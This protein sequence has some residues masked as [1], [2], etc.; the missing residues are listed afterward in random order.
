MIS[1]LQ[2]LLLTALAA[3]S[4]PTILH[5]MGRRLPPTVVFPALRYLTATERE[6][7]RRLKL[8]NLLLL[9]LR[10]L[11][12]VLVVA[13]AARPVAR[14]PGGSSHPPTAVALVVDNSLS[15][16]TVIEGRRV[17]DLLVERAREVV[18]RT[19]LE[20]R[21]WLVLADGI[22]RRQGRAEAVAV[23]DSLAPWA[24]RL[25]LG[26]AVRAAARAVA[27]EPL[28]GHEVVVLSDLQASAL[29]SGEPTPVRVLFADPPPTPANRGIDT[30][31][32]EPPVWTPTGSVIASVGGTADAPV[33]VSLTVNERDVAR[34]V[35]VPGDRVVLAG[36]S[37]RFG[38]Q[39][40][41]VVLDP[42]ELRLDDRW[43]IALRVIPPVAASAAPG[44]GPFVGEALDV[45]QS[46]GRAGRGT[47]V[48]LD[49][50]VG[51]GTTVLFPPADPSLVGAINRA[52]AGRGVPWRLGDLVRGE[53]PVVGDIG[54][55]GATAYR[56]YRLEGAG[57]VLAR[58]GGEPWLVRAGDVVLVASRMEQD[59]TQLPVQAAFVPFVNFL[60]NRLAVRES[61][62]VRAT[63]GAVVELPPSATAALLP[64]G[65]V[66][67]ASDRRLTAPLEPGVYFLRGAAGDTVG[68]VEVN[69]DARES[70]LAP[71][72]ARA[73][74]AAL[75]PD[76]AVLGQR[77]FDRELFRGTRRA[78]LTGLLI[79]LAVVAALAETIVAAAG[80]TRGKA[81]DAPAPA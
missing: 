22:P 18:R 58:A 65:A 3:A 45:L 29:S 64:G 6:H 54:A 19:S 59:W 44:A 13:A 73:V 25:D 41:S 27:A 79:I 52:L 20:D 81:G 55:A 21:L 33:A 11:V 47:E 42:D 9:I 48:V 40:A 31:F 12:I 5:L 36:G 10:T 28:P 1:F 60:V 67:V 14:V 74:R 26:S 37:V 63:P 4:I 80:A 34:A 70:L 53:W 56:R 66:T 17:L 71:A 8:R 16:A 43:W 32:V 62:I 24:V 15:S 78:D 38:W 76:A 23:L 75:G 30:A 61:W 68:A 39:L 77:A 57:A 35:A 72:G 69:H 2:P 51:A 49:D 7:S 46:G 50:Q